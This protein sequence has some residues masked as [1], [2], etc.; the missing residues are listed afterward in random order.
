MYVLLKLRKLLNRHLIDLS[1][2]GLLLVLAGYV[3]ASYALLW[4]A[5]EQDLITGQDFVYW[6]IVTASTVGY[7]DLSPGTPSG[8]LIVALF[9]IPVG[10]SLF[11]LVI[12]RAAA[13]GAAQWKKG[14]RGMKMVNAE[15]HILVIGWNGRRTQHLLKLLLAEAEQ[16]NQRRIVLCTTEDIENPM[17]EEI[18]FVRVTSFTDDAEMSRTALDKASCIIINTSLDDVTMTTALYCNG[19]NQNAH[20]IVYFADDSLSP[21]LK[22]HL[23]RVECMPSVAI[24]MQVKAAMDP[25]SSALH[26]ELLSATHGMTQYSTHYPELLP[27][28]TVEAV[29][30]NFKRS[31]NATL[32]GVSENGEGEIRL[33][34]PLDLQ[35]NPGATLYYIAEKRIREFNWEALD[36]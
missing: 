5:G 2:Q 32:I 12:G 29:F 35:I 31:Y 16:N 22:R 8:K 4:A 14:I 24:E 25:G 1:W 18:G 36:V 13:F 33:N 11:A 34:P 28:A 6:L 15:N 17:P 20:I 3:V 19:H 27:G 23:P 21:L 9:V 30:E 10:L 26:Q 7:G